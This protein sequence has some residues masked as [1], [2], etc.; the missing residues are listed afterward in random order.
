[1]YHAAVRDVVF[2]QALEVDDFEFFRFERLFQVRRVGEVLHDGADPHYASFC[3]FEVLAVS[4]VRMFFGEILQRGPQRI[5]WIV[6]LVPQRARHV[7]EKLIV[8]LQLGQHAGHA[9][10]EI[11]DFVARVHRALKCIR[12]QPTARSIA[13]LASRRELPDPP[14]QASR[15]GDQYDEHRQQARRA[16]ARSP[17]RALA[18]GRQEYRR[19]S[20]RPPRRRGSIARHDRVRRHDDFL[21]IHATAQRDRITAQRRTI[22]LLTTVRGVFRQVDVFPALPHH[23]PVDDRTNQVE[24][25]TGGRRPAGVVGFAISLM[26]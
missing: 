21:V 14:R 16:T 8:L 26:V 13:A 3:A 18:L 24:P 17:V 10:R 25:A 12:P 20:A 11:A 5:Q 19:C 23:E 15:E 7:F 4:D 22:T 1:M 2:D 6:D 9:A